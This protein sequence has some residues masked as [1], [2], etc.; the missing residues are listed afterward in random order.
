MKHKA[1]LENAIKA[2]RERTYYAQYP[3][4]PSGKIYGET[5]N[6]DAKR[7]FEQISQST[8]TQLL[9]EGASGT[10]GEERSPYG[11]PINI[12][13]P[14]FEVETLIKNAQ[15]AQKQWLNLNYAQRA[16]LLIETLEQI[17]NVFFD[18]A[19]ATMHT[20]GQAF[21]MAFQ[22]SGPHA[23]DRALE[24]IAVGYEELSRYPTTTVRWDKPLGKVNAVLDKRFYVVPRGIGLVIG[25]ST[26]PVWNTVPGLYANL[27]TGNPTIVKPH[28][29]A[30]LPIAIWIAKM[31]EVF[32][33]A[34]IDPHIVQLAPD[35]SQNPI[36][37]LLAE[38]PA[39]KLIDFTGSSH[40]GN[41]IESLPNKITFTEKSG[42]NSVI[43]ES[44][45]DV[46]NALENLAFSVS[47]YSGQ[48]CTA[49]QNFFIPKNGV[50]TNVG[51]L[52]FQEVVQKFADKVKALAQNPK[53][54]AG[55]LGAIQSE[56]TYQRIQNTKN[57]GYK[58]ILE[59]QPIQNPEFPNART[60]SPLFIQVEASE[61]DKYAQEL[62]GPIV[63]IIRTENVEQSIELAKKLVEEKGGLTLSIYTAKPDVKERMLQALLPVSISIAFNLSG[64]TWVNQS[65]GFS[66]FHGTG[67]NKAGNAAYTTPEFIVKRFTV[68][69]VREQV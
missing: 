2:L 10:V 60:S 58:I 29:K 11:I 4:A 46:E 24:A 47:L 21:I 52:S 37:K 17:K 14:A 22:A 28:P 35:T 51:H 34:G 13:Y 67:G 48:M 50:D 61:Y 55:V 44:F 66:D 5:A 65:A 8:F 53:M 20:T 56:D 16:D 59:P 7:R 49:P 54:G 43:F 12:Q 42:V 30:I 63:F 62:F 45:V 33:N 38:H 18:I 9:Q 69:G 36:T 31:Q 15:K 26:F 68:V 25:C 41:Y 40:F 32:K 3:E 57:Q 64:P 39:V 6:E 23:A 27:I 1:I 19:Y